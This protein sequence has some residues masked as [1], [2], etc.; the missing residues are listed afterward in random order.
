LEVPPAEPDWVTASYRS[1]SAELARHREERRA[2]LQS[3]REALEKAEPPEKKVK[4]EEVK[5][6]AEK[7]HPGQLAKLDAASKSLESRARFHEPKTDAVCREGKPRKI[8]LLKGGELSRPG[9]EIA[10]GFIAA[11]LP[12]RDSDVPAHPIEGTRAELARWIASKDNPLTARVIVNRVWQHHFGRGLVATASDFGRNGKR[13]THPELLDWLAREFVQNGWS[14]KKLHRLILTSETYQRASSPEAAASA[15]DPENK[16]LW[17]FERRRLDAEA[18]RDTFLAVSGTLNPA[19]GGPGV[20][21]RLPAGINVELP[22]NDKALSWGTAS[23]ADNRRR[24]L[25]LFQRRALTYPLMEVFD[26]APMSQSCAAR[27][28]TTVAPQA[29]ALFN[30]EFTRE[31]AHHFAKRVT[32]ETGDDPA[33]QVARA[34]EIAFARR[35]NEVEKTASLRFLESQREI[36]AGDANRAVQDFC[37]TLLNASELIYPD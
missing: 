26:A 34:F 9:E 29:L 14:L 31:C 25:Y 17:R 12:E 32:S 15:R 7:D 36:R 1:D 3:A 30:G 24:S 13:P 20:Y 16:L 21:A 10:P 22:N 37:H 8:R 6:R 19:P 27:A 11:M 4:D 33:A 18:I 2:L 35:P 5:K 23:E 28:Q